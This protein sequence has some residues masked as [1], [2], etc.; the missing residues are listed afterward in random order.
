MKKFYFV[1]I[2]L[3]CAFQNFAQ[4]E[5]KFELSSIRFAGNSSIS[6]SELEQVIISKESPGWFSQFLSRFTSFGDKAVFFD[7]LQINSDIQALKY[8]Y[9]SKGFFKT[10]ISSRYSLDSAENAAYLEYDI[11]ESQPAFFR[12]FKIGGLE[13]LSAD[14]KTT[15]DENSGVD[16]TVRYNDQFVTNTKNWIVA[17][18]KDH[19]YM[20]VKSDRP[21]LLVDTLLNRVDV[22]LKIDTGKR[23]KISEVSTVKKGEGSE[24][25][26][27]TLLKEIVNINPDSYYNY[28]D[29]QRAQVRLF[30]TD[31]FTG[32]N[33]YGVISDTVRN[34]VPLNISVDVGKLNELAPE[35]IVNNEDNVFNL[36]IGLSYS[37]K[38]FLGDA[39]K[40]TI[41]SSAAAQNIIEFIG[42]PTLS[43][44]TLHGY[45]DAR[46]II[47][48]PFLFGRT[49]NT[50]FETYVTLQKRKREYN[51]TL[52]GGKLT[53]DFELPQ[54][55]YFNAFNTYFNVERS[56]YIY[57]KP[58]LVSLTSLYLQRNTPGLS[59]AEADSIAQGIINTEIG[60]EL[61]SQ[62]TNAYLGFNL[63]SNQTND[64][65][66][67][68]SGN[69]VS[70]LLEDANSIPY[71]ISRLF[72]SDFDRPLYF[73]SIF[74]S[75]LF[76]PV[77]DS[78]VSA[79][80]LKFKIGQIFTYRGDK[81]YIPLNQR[82]Y[83]GGSNSV[84]GWGSRELVPSDAPITS[85]QNLPQED[86]EALLTK[87]AA[88]GGF[89]IMEGSV[90]TRNRLFGKFGSAVFLDWGNTWNGYENFRLDQ[91]AV[92]AGFGIRFYSDFAPI[93]VDFGMKM[94]DP[95]DRRSIFKK[96]F[97]NE[98]MQFHIGIG[99]AF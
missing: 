50:K 17:Y 20:L 11:K 63:G 35:L 91:V 47:E 90:E 62:S 86:L 40:F 6:S 23:Y 74:T 55:T 57:Q 49:I 15:I 66:F 71:L 46:V 31:L 54:F 77:Y 81:G 82:L 80:A 64:V 60:T 68:T 19:G 32:V 16:S 53:L 88:T 4:T 56:K 21:V 8:Y 51:S 24:Y 87:G 44:T 12:N 3:S 79:L 72:K 65:F 18:L 52:Y 76:L 13:N 41:S 39:R 1:I 85:I 30:R 89:F 92:A 83:A 98:V 78:K 28:Y 36:G 61:S 48:Q 84:R 69:S 7:S 34:T 43:D 22:E 96:G 2:L 29:I 58:Y 75:S 97:W 26:E 10:E 5:N 14:L 70:I 73:K 67:P 94:Y 37:K 45:A 25:I 93:R 27:D 38:N 9:Q 33:I 99:E 59:K 42:N 95:N